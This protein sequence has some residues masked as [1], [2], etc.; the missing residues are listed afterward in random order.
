M[1]GVSSSSSG[2]SILGTIVLQPVGT[3]ALISLGLFAREPQA[4]V[5]LL[6]GLVLTN[7]Y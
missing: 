5:L 6:K 7:S 1:A 2:S 3:H 4:F